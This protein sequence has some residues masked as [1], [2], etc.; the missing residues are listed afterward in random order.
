MNQYKSFCVILSFPNLT[1]ICFK[2]LLLTVDKNNRLSRKNNRLIFWKSTK[3]ALCIAFLSFF[4]CD[5]SL[6]FIIPSKFSKI[7]HKQFT[8]SCLR[9]YILTATTSVGGALVGEGLSSR[10]WEGW[11]IVVECHYRVVVA[12]SLP[13]SYSFSG[14]WKARP[15]RWRGCRQQPSLSFLWPYRTTCCERQWVHQL[16]ESFFHH[17]ICNRKN[18]L[19]NSICQPR[20]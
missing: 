4:L 1:Y 18:S 17:D 9:P 6:T 20:K 10:I 13:S 15:W 11:G 7:F 5:S 19:V 8:P 16:P 3:T 2:L 14:R 12:M